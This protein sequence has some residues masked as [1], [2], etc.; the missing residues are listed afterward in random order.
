MDV[1]IRGMEAECGSTAAAVGTF[2]SLSEQEQ[3]YYSELHARCQTDGSGKLSSV[4]VAELFKASQLPPD[5]L[6]KVTEVCGAQRLGYFG[7]AQFYVALKL[8]SAAQSALPL[9]IESVS[10]SK[11][12]VRHP[13]LLSPRQTSLLLS[14]PQISLMLS[15]LRPPSCG[16]LLRPP[17]CGLLLRHPS[18]CLSSD[19]PPVVSSSDLPHVVSSSDLPPVVSSSDLP[20]VVSSSDLP[21]VVSSSDLPPVVSSSDLPPVV[22][23]SDLPHVVSSSDLPPV[24]SSSDLPP[25][26]SSSDLP[27]VVSSSDLPPVVSSSDIPP[28]VSSSDIPPVVSSSDL[29]P[30]VSSS[31]L[32]PV[33]SSSDLPPVVS[34]SD[35]P[36]VVSSSDIPPVVSP[37]TSLLWSPPQTSLLLSPPQTSLLLSPPQT[38]LLLSPPQTSLLL[39]LL[40]HPSCGLLLSL[41]CCLSSDLPL[42]RFVGLQTEAEV[43]YPSAPAGG[44]E[45][46]GPGFSWTKA[47]R[48]TY[49]HVDSAAEKEL[50]SPPRSPSVSPPRS[51]PGYHGYA[52]PRNGTEPHMVYDPLSSRSVAHIETNSSPGHYSISSSDLS[53]APLVQSGSCERLDQQ[54]A[55]SCEDD[56]WRITEEQLQYYTHQFTRL[57][58]DLG[59]LIIGALAKDFFTKSKLPIPEL[60]HIWELSDVDRDG[61]LTFSEFCTAFHLIVAR[62]NGYPLPESLPPPL[63]P[64]Q[65][66]EEE[67][68]EEE[69]E[70]VPDTP[71][72]VEPLIVFEDPE[73]NTQRT[74]IAERLQPQIQLNTSEEDSK[75]AD[76]HVRGAALFQPTPFSFPQRPADENLCQRKTPVPSTWAPEAWLRESASE[77]GA[78][79]KLRRLQ[80][81]SRRGEI[82]SPTS[83]PSPSSP[84]SPTSPPSP[85]SPTSPTSPPSPSSPTSPTSPPSPSSPH[86]THLTPFTHLTHLTPFA[87]HTHLTH[88]T[89]FALH[90]H[91]THLTPFTP[92][93]LK[94]VIKIS[95]QALQS[96]PSPSFINLDHIDRKEESSLKIPGSRFRM[97]SV[98]NS[99]QDLLLGAPQKPA[100]RKFHPEIPNM[101]VPPLAISLA[102]PTKAPQKLLSKQKREIQMAIR[103][104]KETNAV[105][106]RLNSELQQQL[107][108]AHQE[109]VTLESHLELVRPAIVT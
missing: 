42:P 34:S 107:K 12:N 58:P 98:D 24:V 36:P 25:V 96:P 55:V 80:S 84:T 30:V 43:W 88:L 31:D 75:Q 7:T 72:S 41:T 26:V 2:L 106:R 67:D 39:S 86:L 68:E 105:L 71:Q 66:R 73:M 49:R 76:A 83:P 93:R 23:S 74:E 108:V 89:P 70:E 35:L 87:L 61:A 78:A 92:L 14:P 99:A 102:P 50:W 62:K 54:G 46:T 22:S 45:G 28:V 90:T 40:R 77:Q 52:F 103:K 109:R 64:V 9:R 51:P 19:L 47:D 104:N 13:G 16:L 48:N 59:A 53:S 65:E 21:P 97:S 60:S 91:L 8:L 81:L 27:H 29:P 44:G 5:A 11:S 94:P 79:A 100:R 4:R 63:R 38:S 17:S 95:E 6:H 69:E 15:L 57:Q 101:D 82:P 32:P 33:V 1:P 20:P 18:C 37:Q 3:R 85:S 56:P 10:A